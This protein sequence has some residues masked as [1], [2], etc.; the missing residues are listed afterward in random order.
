M[1]SSKPMTYW[2]ASKM[3][4]KTIVLMA[5]N[6]PDEDRGKELVLNAYIKAGYLV[7]RHEKYYDG[8]IVKTTGV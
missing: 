7:T 6:L 2:T 3:G 8:R 1:S 4:G 5:I